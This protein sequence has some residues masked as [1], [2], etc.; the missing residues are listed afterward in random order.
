MKN[1]SNIECIVF[2][3]DGTLIMSHENIYLS[4]LRTFKE[5]EIEVDIPK[6]KFYEMIGHHFQDI[7][8]QFKIEVGDIE[9]FIDLYKTFYFDYIDHS[10]PYP[11]V[12]ELLDKLKT[13][14]CKTGLLTTKAQDQA[15]R[16][17][18]HFQLDKYLNYVAGRKPGMPI[19]PAPEPLLE[20]CNILEV[21]PQKTLMVGDTEM[22]IQCGKN[23]GAVTCAVTFGYRTKEKL[24]N[25]NPDYIIDNIAD[26]NIIL[27]GNY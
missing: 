6:D 27:N 16:I 7:F 18:T 15:R 20:V 13:Q 8:D 1:N 19:K 21:D 25:D 23:A 14:G 22:D 11:G 17:A 26:I 10:E 4:T 9:H 5:F 2:D 24:E 3:L 12:I